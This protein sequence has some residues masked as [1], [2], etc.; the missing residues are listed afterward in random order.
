MKI[1]KTIEIDT[2]DLSIDQLSSELRTRI[3]E[4]FSLC[5][6]PYQ[7]DKQKEIDYALELF[8]RAM[9]W[10]KSPFLGDWKK[11]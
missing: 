1:Y 2:Y 11:Q 8:D 4:K 9:A 7:E 6:I 3:S 5:S 10:Y